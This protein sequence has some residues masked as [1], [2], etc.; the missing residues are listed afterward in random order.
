[1]P[2]LVGEEVAELGAQVAEVLQGLVLLRVIQALH[3]PNLV[4]D[5]ENLC[6]GVI[7][8]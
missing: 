1:V 2:D 7:R 6:F 8:L 5:I 3:L 4:P